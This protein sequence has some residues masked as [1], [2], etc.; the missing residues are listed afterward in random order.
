MGWKVSVVTRDVLRMH[1]SLR[2][3]YERLKHTLA[4]EHEE[5]KQYSMGKAP[6][7][8]RVLEMARSDE[9]LQYEFDVPAL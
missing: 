3:E 8:R 9:D 5:I 4:S 7:I 2:D 6:F 1:P